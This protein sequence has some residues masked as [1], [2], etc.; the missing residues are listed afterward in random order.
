MRRLFALAFGMILGG[1]LVFSAF[2]Y[3]LVRT[4]RGFYF[5]K[6]RQSTLDDPY[7]DIRHWEGQEWKAHPTLVEAVVAGGHSD[8]IAPAHK[9]GPLR[10]F[11]SRLRPKP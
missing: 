1:I 3:H 2:Q 4:D 9:E 8:W 7:V 11:F 6:K 10:E 5:V